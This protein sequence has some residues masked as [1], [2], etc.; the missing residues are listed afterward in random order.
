MEN[1]VPN[2]KRKVNPGRVIRGIGLIWVVLTLVLFL[3]VRRY[4]E[5]QHADAIRKSAVKD[6]VSLLDSG[7]KDLKNRI[8]GKGT[9]DSV[10]V[11]AP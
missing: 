7:L 4:H 9:K 6:S 1:Q 8:P 10:S 3:L 11:P 5:I 2:A